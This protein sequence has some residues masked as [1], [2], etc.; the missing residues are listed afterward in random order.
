[1]QPPKEFKLKNPEFVYSNN[2]CMALE[3]SLEIGPEEGK[4]SK[5]ILTFRTSQI[6]G[7]DME[8]LFEGEYDR[9]NKKH[10]WTGPYSTGAVSIQFNGGYEREIL[11]AAFQKIGL[12]TIPVYGKIDRGPF[13]PNEEE[14]NAL[15]QQTPSV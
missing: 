3:I 4:S 15:R 7:Y 2:D 6:S 9:V 13:E 14:Q 10:T 11:I 1:M 5:T 12:M 8:V